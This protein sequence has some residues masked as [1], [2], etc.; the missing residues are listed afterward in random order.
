[1]GNARGGVTP[2]RFSGGTILGVSATQTGIWT[3][4]DWRR[5]PYSG[6]TTRATLRA[7]S[8][9]GPCGT[10]ADFVWPNVLPFSCEAADEIIGCS[11]DVARLRLLQRRVSRRHEAR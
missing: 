3:A 6:S 4:R 5:S 11:Q 1:M 10:L 2:E 8:D 7:T 9:M